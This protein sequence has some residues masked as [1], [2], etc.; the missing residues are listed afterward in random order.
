M[1]KIVDAPNSSIEVGGCLKKIEYNEIVEVLRAPTLGVSGI[2]HYQ[3]R[4]GGV[5][6]F[7]LEGDG[8]VNP[9]PTFPS[10]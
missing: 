10:P 6:I 3:K 2:E 4:V 9:T 1:V 5:K 7:E 8:I